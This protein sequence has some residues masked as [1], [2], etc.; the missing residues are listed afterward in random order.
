[1][2]KQTHTILVVED[3]QR[4]L[5]IVSD[6][7]TTYGFKV[8]STSSPS[9]AVTKCSAENADIDLLLSDVVMPEMNCVQL[10]EKLRKQRPGLKALFM[11]GYPDDA[12]ENIVQ[13]KDM[14]EVMMKPFTNRELVDKVREILE[15]R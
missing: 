2:P 4:V 11:S 6:V 5:D 8:I 10:L 1:M 12:I 3:D 9:D 14:P 7:L 15:E 13:R